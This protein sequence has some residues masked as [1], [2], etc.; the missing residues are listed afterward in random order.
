MAANMQCR[1]NEL[2][3]DI[4]Q[5]GQMSIFD[6][7]QFSS[8]VEGEILTEDDI[9]EKVRKHICEVNDD[10]HLTVFLAEF[11]NKYGVICPFKTLHKILGEIESM[12]DIQVIRNPSQTPSGKKSSFWDEKGNH[13]VVI[14]RLK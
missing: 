12:G 3:L 7:P 8:T 6:M 2:F 9:E 13:S 11:C 14:R 4:Q 1:K 10:T 5:R